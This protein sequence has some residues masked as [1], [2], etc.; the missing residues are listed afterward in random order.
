MKAPA[1]ALLWWIDAVAARP[2]TVVL[3]A[4][5]LAGISLVY[6]LATLRIDTDTTDM[7]AADVPFR[8]HDRAFARAFPAFSHPIVAVIEGQ[9]PERVRF[10]ATALADALRAD[11]DHFSAVDYAAGLPFFA[12]HGLLYLGVDEVALLTDRLAEAQ[13]LLAALAEDPTLR[14]LGTFTTLAID[15]QRGDAALPAELDQLFGDMAAVADAQTRGVPAELSWHRLLDDDDPAV[16]RQLVLA[17]P[18]LDYASLAPAGAAIEALRAAADRLGIDSTH[19]LQLRLTGAAV[20]EDEEL[21]SVASGALTAVVITTVAVALLLF[22]GL[23]SWRL[24]TATLLTLAVGL[25]VTAGFTALAIGRLNLISVAFA[26]LFVGLGVD[27]GIHV[28]LRY[29]EQIQQAVG[30]TL[31]IER[32]GQGV[33]GALTLTA[34]CAALGFLSFVPTA[35]L[36]LAELGIISAFGMLVAWIASLTLLPALLRLMP[37]SPAP[38]TERPS[39]LLPIERHSRSILTVAGIAGIASLLALPYLTFDFDP[40]NLKDPTAESVVTFHL[41]KADADTSPHVIEILEPSLEQAD[42]TAR[43]LASLAPVASARTVTSL[44]PEAQDEKL[45]LIDSLAWLIGPLLQPGDTAALN[46]HQ[47][48]QALDDLERTLDQALAGDQAAARNPGGAALADALR[49]LPE[50]AGAA[51]AELETR[52]MGLLPVLLEDL[53]RALDADRIR[54]EDLPADV[55]AQWLTPDGQARVLVRPAWQIESSGELRAFAQA[56]LA[57]VPHA[58]GTPI[59]VV[60]GGG[61]VVLAFEQASALALVLIVVLLGLVLRNVRD[62]ILVLAPILLAAV[63]TAASA[64][65]LGLSLNFANVIVLPLL[66]GL[67]VSGAIHVVMRERQQGDIVGT[68]TPRAVVFS[69]LTTIASFGSLALSKHLG[70]ASMGQLLSIAILWSLVCTLVVLPSMLAF[71]AGQRVRAPATGPR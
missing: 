1:R 53:R 67:G 20:L 71:A 51:P 43:R 23:R 16:A 44:V 54:L 2:W 25:V 38:A 28:V 33:A 22:W 60:E 63:L 40:L 61:A 37:L 62:V 26:V 65:L 41:L 18:R 66:L 46:A 69:G 31:A 32:A 45:E 48:A 59:V 29:Q 21:E 11:H 35:Y 27:F 39:L 10:A 9:A 49:R 42:R 14:G 5:L 4:L 52:L 50:R 8:Q 36:G 15:Q 70:L 55:R 24:I 58:T 17:Q 47:R 7:I 6:T 57:E 34:V 68:S 56:I 12:E 3:A 13:P 19:G 30:Q 64:V